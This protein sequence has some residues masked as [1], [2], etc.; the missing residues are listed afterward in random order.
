[1]VMGGI[2]LAAQGQGITGFITRLTAGR[3]K[4]TS[5]LLKAIVGKGFS[6][7]LKDGFPGLIRRLK[8]SERTLQSNLWWSDIVGDL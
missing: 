5:D 7:S 6:W 8:R 4:V 1:M 3:L 2:S